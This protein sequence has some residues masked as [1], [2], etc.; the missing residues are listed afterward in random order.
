MVFL[1]ALLGLG[2]GVFLAGVILLVA[3]IIYQKR[4][5]NPTLIRWAG[6]VAMVIGF[7]VGVIAL[8]WR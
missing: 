2:I 5:R 3:S 4:M 7:L 1:F 8:Y 6:V